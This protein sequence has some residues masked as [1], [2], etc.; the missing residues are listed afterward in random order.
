MVVRIS[1]GLSRITGFND[2]YATLTSGGRD[3]RG[4]G[5]EGLSKS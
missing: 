2:Q 1:S 5:D 3:E 4:E